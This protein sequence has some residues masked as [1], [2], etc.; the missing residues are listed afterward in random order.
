M[1]C[2]RRVNNLSKN[3]KLT[4]Q[5]LEATIIAIDDGVP[6]ELWHIFMQYPPRLCTALFYEKLYIGDVASWGCYI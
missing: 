2:E 6:I 1:V 3:G 5:Q 4:Y